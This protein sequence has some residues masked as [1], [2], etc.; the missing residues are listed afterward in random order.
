LPH[1]APVVQAVPCTFAHVPFFAGVAHEL[2]ASHIALPQQTPSVQKSPVEHV[3][4]AAHGSPS[5]GAGTHAPSLQRFP[6]AQSVSAV[7]VDLHDATSHPYVPHARGMSLHLPPPS[8]VL[9]WVSIPAEH[10][11]WLHAGLPAGM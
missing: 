8:Q 5:P 9:A 3:P 2:P 4:E 7:H 10:A 11:F 6:A 1:S